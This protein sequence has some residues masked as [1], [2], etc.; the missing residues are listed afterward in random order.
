[1]ALYL[2]HE[3]EVKEMERR[4]WKGHKSP[5]HFANPVDIYFSK[6]FQNEYVTPIE[7][8]YEMLRKKDCECLLECD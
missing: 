1:M 3:A 5:L 6:M 8:Q 2:R 7:E 4:G